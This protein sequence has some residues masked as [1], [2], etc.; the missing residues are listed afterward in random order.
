MPFANIQVF[1]LHCSNFQNQNLKLP[2]LNI[3]VPASGYTNN[4]TLAFFFLFWLAKLLSC[5]HTQYVPCICMYIY[6]CTLHVFECELTVCLWIRFRMCVLCNINLHY[7][8]MHIHTCTNVS[9]AFRFIYFFV[10]FVDWLFLPSCF[11]FHVCVKLPDRK[12]FNT[13]ALN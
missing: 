6:V 12:Y 10:C 9:S 3:L 8:F 4:H 5:T 11:W 13:F 2:T 1:Q 7:L